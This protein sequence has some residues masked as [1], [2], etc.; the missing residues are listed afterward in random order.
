MSD[1]KLHTGDDF[2]ND[3]NQDLFFIKVISHIHKRLEDEI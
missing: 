1:Y 3:N 2:E